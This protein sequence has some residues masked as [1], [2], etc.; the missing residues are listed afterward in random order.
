MEREQNAFESTH[1]PLE[2]FSIP[3]R[4]HGTYEDDDL[5]L[6]PGSVNNHRLIIHDICSL[7][8]VSDLS[9]KPKACVSVIWLHILTALTVSSPRHG[10]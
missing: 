10:L 2:L 5:E 9:T 3:C 1:R 4:D 7:L 8:C 6:T